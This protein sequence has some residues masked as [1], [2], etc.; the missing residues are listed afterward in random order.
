MAEIAK[1]RLYYFPAYGRAEVIRIALR[2]LEIPYEEEVVLWQSWPL[3]KYSGN[4]EFNQLPMLEIDGKRLV[5]SC[6]ILRYICQSHNAYSSSAEDATRIEAIVELR[7]EIQESVLPMLYE[8]N[9][10]GAKTWYVDRMPV[11]YFPMLEALL[12][13]NEAGQGKYFVGD[14][15][16]MADF[17][18]FEFGFNAFQRPQMNELG[19]KFAPISPKFFAFLKSFRE[20]RESLRVYMSEPK[21]KPY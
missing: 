2:Y 14:H 7:G 19:V 5:Q 3:Q 21:D 6:S 1:P 17:V 11:H 4:Y 9:L 15:A 18:M 20:E 10:I 8:G 13:D 16:T 12:T